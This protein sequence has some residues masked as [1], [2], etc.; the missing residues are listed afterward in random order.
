MDVCAC[1]GTGPFNIFDDKNLQGEA[2]TLANAASPASNHDLI[3]A[4]G[5]NAS[6]LFMQAYDSTAWAGLVLW[7]ARAGGSCACA[8]C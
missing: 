5:H 4:G 7:C 6:G 3:Y 8:C 1:P 2:G